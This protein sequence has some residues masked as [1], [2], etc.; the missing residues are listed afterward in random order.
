MCIVVSCDVY[1]QRH[2]TSGKLFT[3]NFLNIFF[4]LLRKC[5]FVLSHDFSV[6]NITLGVLATLLLLPGSLLT[7]KDVLYLC[8]WMLT[9]F[10]T[11]VIWAKSNTTHLHDLCTAYTPQQ[12]DQLSPCLWGYMPECL[13]RSSHDWSRYSLVVITWARS[14]L[15]IIKRDPLSCCRAAVPMYAELGSDDDDK[16]SVERSWGVGD[17]GAGSPRVTSARL[18]SPA[19]AW[20]GTPEPLCCH[21]P[22]SFTWH[23]HTQKLYCIHTWIQMQMPVVSL[24]HLH[25]TVQYC[26]VMHSVLS[27]GEGQLHWKVSAAIVQTL[28]FQD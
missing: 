2:P 9:C 11:V 1:N 5:N 16:A 13:S 4:D 20:N 6:G 19:A 18:R 23:T 27:L 12:C 8:T 22:G 14:L 28:G 21:Q 10:A 26:I 7:H 17:E 15:L 25:C 24:S 3:L